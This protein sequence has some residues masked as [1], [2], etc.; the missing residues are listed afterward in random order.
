MAVTF[1]YPL[2][3]LITGHWLQ[4]DRS[5]SEELDFKNRFKRTREL[6]KDK[7]FVKSFFKKY[8]K[9]N[10]KFRWLVMTPDPDFSQKFNANLKK[11]IQKALKQK[12]LSQYE[13]EYKDYKSWVS[14]KEDPEIE[15]KR[16][17]LELSDLKEEPSP[18]EF[19]KYSL[20]DSEII[21][22]PSVTYG[23][24]YIDLF[25]DLRGVSEKNIKHLNLF[26]GLLKR[27]DTKNLS[28][29]DISKKVDRVIG[30][31]DFGTQVYQSAKETQTFKPF[32]KVS[33]GFLDKN[34]DQIIKNFKRAFSS[35]SVFPRI[36]S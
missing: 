22:F 17:L 2:G 29:K 1:F 30:K 15:K 9:E 19:N 32:M 35:Q 27:T 5:L 12:T 13:K 26:T 23:V 31:L 11:Q 20:E 28:F 8:L 14:S 7:N 33:L 24:S 25:F 4:S 3:Q 10:S 36:S 21:E 6:L 18:P 34:N 16:P